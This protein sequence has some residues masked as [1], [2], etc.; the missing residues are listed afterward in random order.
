MTI[1]Q[2]GSCGES[3]QEP[4]SKTDSS[5]PKDRLYGRR[6]GHPLRDRQK[7]LLS[8]YLPRIKFPTRNIK[9]PFEAF[10]NQPR[11]LWLEIGFGGGEHSLAQHQIHSDIGYIACEVFENG[12]CSLLSN[13][14]RE[15]VKETEATVPNMLRIWNEDARILI[16]ALPENS[17]EKIFLLFPDPWPK[18][19]HAKRRFVHPE[20]LPLLHRILTSKGQW[21]IAS[22]DPTYQAW[23]EETMENQP[24]FKKIMQTNKRPE[25][26]P[27]T[28]YEQKAYKA[29]R[30]P[31]FWIFE[32]S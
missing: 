18:T 5:L 9:H 4:F 15:D 27:P 30:S 32:K 8:D 26:W 6:R 29:G 28:R 23:V 21:H 20:R 14:V 11:A 17:I 24:Y 31:I 16:R 25:N 3:T 10:E 12:I 19:R 22:D 2:K 13:L 7:R 1:I